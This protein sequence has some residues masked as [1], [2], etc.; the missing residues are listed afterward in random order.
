MQLQLTQAREALAYLPVKFVIVNAIGELLNSST[1]K[2]EEQTILSVAIFPETLSKLNLDA[3][4]PSDAMQN[5]VHNTKFFKA[6]GFVPVEKLAS[7]QF[8]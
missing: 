5:F 4:D 6:A 3:V 1:G 7:E 8:L 2:I